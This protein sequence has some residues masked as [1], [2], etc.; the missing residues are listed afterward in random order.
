MQKNNWSR[1]EHIIAFNL[2]CKID[3]AKINSNHPD[4]YKVQ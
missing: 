1:E 2:Y 4:D 3:F